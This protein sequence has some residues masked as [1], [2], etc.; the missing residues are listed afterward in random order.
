M[1][2]ESANSWEEILK[3]ACKHEDDGHMSKLIRVTA[4]ARA[5]SEKYNH[6]PE[7]RMKQ[8]MFLPA[9]NAALDSVFHSNGGQPMDGVLHFDFVRG[10]AWKEAWERVP[11]LAPDRRLEK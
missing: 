1:V 9:A 6:L 8:H 7:F 4:H 10:C 2:P 5:I 3:R 11:E